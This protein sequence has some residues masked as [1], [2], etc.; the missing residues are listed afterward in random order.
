MI[1]TQHDFIGK[2]SAA[3]RLCNNYNLNQPQA[4]FTGD[5]GNDEKLWETD[6]R[7]IA[8]NCPEE[9]MRDSFK[10]VVDSG[11]FLDVVKVILGDK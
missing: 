1:P 9:R 11:D 4:S 3:I 10:F 7:T 8:F 2:K 6:L 5:R